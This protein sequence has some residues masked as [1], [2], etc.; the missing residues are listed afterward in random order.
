MIIALS[1][2]GVSLRRIPAC[3]F[4]VRSMMIAKHMNKWI[5]HTIITH[6]AS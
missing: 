2:F 6:K 3:V 4:C 1:M 5:N